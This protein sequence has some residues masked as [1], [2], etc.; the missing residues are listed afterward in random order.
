MKLYSRLNWISPTFS[1]GSLVSM[2]M[3]TRDSDRFWKNAIWLVNPRRGMRLSQCWD[4]V[5]EMLNQSENVVVPVVLERY[6]DRVQ[7]FVGTMLKPCWGDVEAMLVRCCEYDNNFK[8]CRR[9]IIG[10]TLYVRWFYP[11]LGWGCRQVF[12]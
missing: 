10:S 5:E 1:V 8:H 9:K 6:W 3:S 12:S 4:D 11:T 7:V 2:Y